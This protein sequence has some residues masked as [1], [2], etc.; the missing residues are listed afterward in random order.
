MSE[1]CEKQLPECMKFLD[2]E[3]INIHCSCI[4]ISVHGI[5]YNAYV[6]VDGGYVKIEGND[7]LRIPCNSWDIEENEYLDNQKEL[8]FRT[9]TGEVSARIFLEK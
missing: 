3:V 9:M 6:G 5:I 7:H 2:I 8:V 1:I 4:K